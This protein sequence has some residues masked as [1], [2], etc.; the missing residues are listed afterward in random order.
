[1]AESTPPQS[2]E[3]TPNLQKPLV[4][5]SYC[6]LCGVF[7]SASPDPYLLLRAELAHTCSEWLKI[8]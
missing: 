2:F 7:V 5:E 3:H 8:Y 6:R 4:V 1:M